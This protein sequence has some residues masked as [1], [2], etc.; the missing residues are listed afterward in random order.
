MV[1]F[2]PLRS[3][4]TLICARTTNSEIETLDIAITDQAGKR[5]YEL[6]SGGEAFRVNF[7]IRIERKQR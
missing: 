7:A 6:F 1:I 4:G 2:L 5:P 3:L